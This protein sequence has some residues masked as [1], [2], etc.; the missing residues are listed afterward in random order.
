MAWELDT[1][2]RV[3]KHRYR[4][5]GWFKKKAVIICA[6]FPSI[7]YRYDIWLSFSQ[8]N[9]L[10]VANSVCHRSYRKWSHCQ[11]A[12][13]MSLV[14]PP[15]KSIEMVQYVLH[16]SWTLNCT[17]ESIDGFTDGARI[18]HLKI[19]LYWWHRAVHFKWIC[20]LRMLW[21]INVI[22]RTTARF[23]TNFEFSLWIFDGKES[24][25]A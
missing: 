20:L 1:G 13:A 4:A 10:L 15:D 8:I 23:S 25:G 6:T 7:F 18:V 3:H 17:I 16:S 24:L 22:H 9:F 2:Y 11:N 5:H 19:A 14:I 21:N 12:T